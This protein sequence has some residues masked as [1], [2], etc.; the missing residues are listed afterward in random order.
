MIEESPELKPV[1]R[2]KYAPLYRYLASLQVREL[3]TTFV[4]L[5]SILG[6]KLPKSARRWPAWWANDHSHV[7]A[8]AWLGAE[9]ETSQVD[10]KLEKVTFKSAKPGYSNS[11]MYT[12]GISDLAARMAQDEDFIKGTEQGLL[13]IEEGRYS[14][15]DDVKRR[16]SDL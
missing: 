7:H 10:L 8:R 12:R 11:Y 13:D 6:F 1:E 16:L 2:S 4:Q 15:L 9:W 14:T 3:P 5:E